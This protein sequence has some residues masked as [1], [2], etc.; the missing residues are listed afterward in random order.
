MNPLY[1]VAEIRQ[2]EEAAAR[3]LPEGALM[4]RAG[5]AAANAALDLLPF[6]TSRARVLVLAGPGNNGGDALEASA[7]LAF[8]GA[9]ITIL[10]FAGGQPTSAEREQA[11]QRA[12]GS[13]AKFEELAPAAIAAQEWNLVVDGLFG[14][15]LKRPLEGAMRA[16]VDAVNALPCQRLALDVPSGLDADSGAIVGPDGAAVRATH[17]ITFIGDKPGLHTCDGRDCA[18]AVQV[19]R[20][21]IEPTLFQSSRQHLNDVKFFSRHLRA[22]RHNTHKGSYGNVAVIGGARGMAGA[23]ILAARAALMS[24]AGR[25]YACF[26]E[27]A[28]AYDGAHPELM[29][30]LAGDFDM[31]SAALAAGPGLGTGPAARA[32]LARAIGSGSPLLLDADALNLLAAEPALQAAL[33]E[34]GAPV[35]VTPHPLEAARLLGVSVTVVQADRLSAARELAQRLRAVVVLKGSGTV[36]ATQDGHT[37]INTTGNPALATAGTGDVLSGLC[38][39]L[40]AQGWPAWEAALAAVWLHG[41]A[42][43]VLVTEGAGPIGVT[44]GELIPAIR[45]ALNRM[46]QHHAR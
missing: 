4:Q 46:V 42:A 45:T 21:D 38:A 8:A 26:A 7:H 23:A 32:A 15:G 6:S 1:T 2:I 39:S 29:C 5:Q 44:A 36:L 14:I 40:L 34:R 35:V 28:P 31:D 43:D 12:R 27:D 18:G 25:V 24:G 22:R 20:L 9:Q 17:T 41:M 37:V 11:L 3:R 33:A 19:A 13:T 30:R 16:L 10:H